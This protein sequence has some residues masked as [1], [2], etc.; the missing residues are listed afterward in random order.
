MK[1]LIDPQTDAIAIQTLVKMG[2][3]PLYHGF[4]EVFGMANYIP[5]VSWC[6]GQ[7]QDRIEDI[8]HHAHGQG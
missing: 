4:E 7:R 5:G 1:N 3:G 6:P 8:V 2:L